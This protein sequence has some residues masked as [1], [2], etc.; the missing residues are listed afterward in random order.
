MKLSTACIRTVRQWA[1]FVAQVGGEYKHKDFKVRLSC[2]AL[3]QDPQ[4]MTAAQPQWQPATGLSS[5]PGTELPKW[6]G[7]KL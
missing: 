6:P 7:L 4:G 3:A 2:A 5:S 1:M